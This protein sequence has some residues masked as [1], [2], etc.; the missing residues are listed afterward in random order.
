MQR[1]HNRLKT[2]HRFLLP[3]FCYPLLAGSV[4][5]CALL[6]ARFWLSDSWAYLHLVWNLVLAWVPYGC[7]LWIT[8]LAQRP[9]TRWWRLVVPGSV[10]LLFL[11]NAPYLVTEFVHLLEIPSFALWFDIVMLATFAWVGCFLAV[12]SLRLVQLQL[13]QSVG[14]WWSWTSVV[15]VLGLTGLGVYLGRFRRWNSW[16]IVLQPQALLSDIIV[17]VMNPLSHLRMYGVTLVFA[18][19][20]FVC[21][22]TCTAMASGAGRLSHKP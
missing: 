17:H 10:G 12:A 5:A 19:F 22:I 7:S 1:F 13:V 18:A 15:A 21:Y 14:L 6:L 11:P 9:G 2:T 16:D 4:C 20:L 8:L 3:R